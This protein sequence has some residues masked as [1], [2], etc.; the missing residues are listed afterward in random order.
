MFCF[1]ACWRAGLSLLCT[2]VSMS[3]QDL[4]TICS[5]AYRDCRQLRSD[6]SSARAHSCCVSMDSRF[7][8][9][10][11]HD[12][13]DRICPACEEPDS[14]ESIHHV[15]SHCPVY[16]CRRATL[17]SA[18]AGLPRA[19]AFPPVLVGDKGVVA[20]SRNEFMGGAQQA[21]IA[22]DSFLHDIITLRTL[23]VEQFGV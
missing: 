2:S 18:V 4:G 22:V 3:A 13:E 12:R 11:S 19:H 5:E 14:I 1:L 9:Q 21:A 7:R 10:P 6:L 17:R 23:C 15:L 8:D 20:L 16:E